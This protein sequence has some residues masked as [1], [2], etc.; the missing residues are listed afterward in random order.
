MFR[1]G[2]GIYEYTLSL[3]IT[4]SI[5]MVDKVKDSQRVTYP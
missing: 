4:S 5:L 1:P 3:Y 2:S